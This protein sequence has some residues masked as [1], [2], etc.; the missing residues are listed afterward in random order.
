MKTCSVND[1]QAPHY[2]K[3]LCTKHYQRVAATG[4]TDLKIRP[5]IC[6][7]DGCAGKVRGHGL[8]S[9]HYIRFRTHG[10]VLKTVFIV[11]DAKARLMQHC[12]VNDSGCWEWQKFKLEGY[13]ITSLDGHREQAHRASWKVH[14]G[15]IPD[16]IQVNHKCRNRC[17]I[18]P[19][20]LYLGTQK[21][22]MQDMYE[23]GRANRASGEANGNNVLSVA[24]VVEI[25]LLIKAGEKGYK[26]AAKYG[27]APTTISAIK[28]GYTW[29]HL[30]GTERELLEQTKQETGLIEQLETE[31]V[32]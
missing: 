11:G 20:H 9:K 3:G 21:E 6:S 31:E 30:D 5:T 15:P 29:R 16:G 13:G 32:C 28:N 17:C 27:V 22:N 23:A 8:C 7:V 1:C 14:K 2:A 18:N 10:D 24:A 26:I 4:T 12:I 25:K 19:G